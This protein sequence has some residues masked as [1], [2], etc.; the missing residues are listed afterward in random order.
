MAPRIHIIGPRTGHRHTHTV[1]FLHGRDSNNAEFAD[2]F[3]ESEASE[4]ANQPRTLLDLFPTVRWVFPTA[5]LTNSERFDAMMSQWFD[6][7]SAEEPEERVELQAPGLKQSVAEVLELIGDEEAI[8][9]RRNIFLGGISQGFATALSAFLAGGQGLAGL[10]GLCS[11]MPCAGVVESAAC[12]IAD[13][14]QLFS[15]VRDIYSGG[16]CACPIDAAGLKSTPIFLGHAA[17]DD[18]VPIRNGKRMWN[19][20]VGGLQ[21]TTYFHEYADGG[22]WVNEPKGVDDMAEFLNTRMQQS[23]IDVEHAQ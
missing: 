21:L 20:L 7:W 12:S 13:E 2:E 1:I 9:P 23:S 22:H 5:T 19:I 4:P 16:K 8:V 3:F 18:V 11:W 15:A 17:D 14:G 10:I 6:M